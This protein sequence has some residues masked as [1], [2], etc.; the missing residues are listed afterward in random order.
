MQDRPHVTFLSGLLLA[1]IILVT[2]WTGGEITGT[3]VD[4]IAIGGV[5]VRRCQALVAGGSDSGDSGSPVFGAKNRRGVARDRVILL[6]ILWGGSI[7]GP[8]E[9]VYSPMFNIER[10]LGLL[11]TH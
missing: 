6:G 2:G 3:C 7:D 9:F 5:F 1:S 8:P 10:D 11:R 4:V